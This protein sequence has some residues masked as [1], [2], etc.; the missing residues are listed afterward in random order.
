M[1]GVK[2]LHQE[3]ENVSKGEYI[4]GHLFG[5]IGI[6][7]GDSRK[8]FSLPLFMNLQD[9]IQTILGWKQAGAES[10]RLSH[11]VQM[12]EQPPPEKRQIG[13]TEG[14]LLD[15]CCRFSN[16]HRSPVR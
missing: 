4:F 15:S 16:H 1:P 8:W 10:E 5:A 7:V 12:I 11:I 13:Q 6:L 2:K 9:G 14:T 3:S